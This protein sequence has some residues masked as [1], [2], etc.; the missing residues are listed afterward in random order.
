M[1]VFPALARMVEFWW[2]GNALRTC[3]PGRRKGL[4]RRSGGVGIGAVN[5]DETEGLGAVGGNRRS[6]REQI[7]TLF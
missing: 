4:G 5:G 3:E 1:M 6:E 2:N 7:K